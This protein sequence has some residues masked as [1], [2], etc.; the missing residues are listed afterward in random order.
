MPAHRS[1]QPSGRESGHP[2][3]K[4]GVHT[5]EVRLPSSGS[6]APEKGA[7]VRLATRT[8]LR[9]AHTAPEVQVRSLCRRTRS[10]PRD[11]SCYTCVCQKC[12]QAKCHPS[13]QWS[14]RL[15]DSSS[16]SH[17]TTW[18]CSQ[19][20]RPFQRGRRCWRLRLLQQCP[21][22]CSRRGPS[23]RPLHRV[24]LLSLGGFLRLPVW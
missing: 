5:Q 19:R 6:E 10:P 23:Q 3:T 24:P 2:V 13:A 7:S 17:V 18:I 20:W 21:A 11:A 8:E 22:R 16:A 9:R 12:A 4:C 14:K 15:G 1:C